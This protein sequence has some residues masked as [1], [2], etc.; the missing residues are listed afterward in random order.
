MKIRITGM[1]VITDGVQESP[2]GDEERAEGNDGRTPTE[3]IKA[4]QPEGGGG[5]QRACGFREAGKK[6]GAVQ[7]SRESPS[8]PGRQERGS[9]P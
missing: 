8:L 3:E 9:D 4:E 1:Y 2:Q 7:Q 5:N 6:E